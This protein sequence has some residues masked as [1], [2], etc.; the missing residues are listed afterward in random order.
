[1][2]FGSGLGQ[3]LVVT[4]KYGSKYNEV[5]GQYY[6]LPSG[7][8][9]EFHNIIDVHFAFAVLLIDSSLAQIYAESHL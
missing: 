9:A 2:F 5:N 3:D 1:M 7:Q 8:R 4:I 6:S